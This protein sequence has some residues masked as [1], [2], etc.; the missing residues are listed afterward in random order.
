METLIFQA[1][2]VT[3]TTFSELLSLRKTTAT[4]F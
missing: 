2:A 1:P 4:L 3:A